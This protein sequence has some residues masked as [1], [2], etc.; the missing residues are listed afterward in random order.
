M[1]KPEVLHAAMEVWTGAPYPLG[2][3]WD[4]IFMTIEVSQNVLTD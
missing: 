4:W 2:A 3:T 1:N